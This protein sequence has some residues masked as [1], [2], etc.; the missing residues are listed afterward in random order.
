MRNDSIVHMYIV[1]TEINLNI[2]GIEL[3]S[4]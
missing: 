2:Q 1:V 3:F 4:K